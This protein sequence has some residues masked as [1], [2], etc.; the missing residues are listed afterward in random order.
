[1][2][3]WVNTLQLSGFDQ[4]RLPGL[5]MVPQNIFKNIKLTSQCFNT[6]NRPMDA[7]WSTEDVA[8]CS[9]PTHLHTAHGPILPSRSWSARHWSTSKISLWATPPFAS[10]CTKIT[11]SHS[12]HVDVPVQNALSHLALYLHCL[13]N[14]VVLAFSVLLFAYTSFYISVIAEKNQTYLSF[15]V[16]PCTWEPNKY[17]V[18]VS[19]DS[20]LQVIVVFSEFVVWYTDS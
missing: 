12:L 19:L 5:Q 10:S 8:R 1:M 13:G 9:S 15:A 7:L 20:Y 16:Q 3:M 14:I 18:W 4:A 17:T 6:S 11:L 2:H